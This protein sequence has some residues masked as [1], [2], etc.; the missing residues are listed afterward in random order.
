MPQLSDADRKHETPELER[1]DF[2]THDTANSMTI[3]IFL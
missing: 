1:K 2:I 3:N